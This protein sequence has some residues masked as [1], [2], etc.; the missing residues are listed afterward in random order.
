MNKQQK[1]K[2]IGTVA[3]ALS[4]GIDSATQLFF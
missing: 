4:G 3:V 2:N 1:L